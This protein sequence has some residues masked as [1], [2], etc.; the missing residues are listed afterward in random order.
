MRDVGPVGDAAVGWA[1]RRAGRE[2]LVRRGQHDDLEA[3]H[4]DQ[5]HHFE[6]VGA[7]RP[8]EPPPLHAAPSDHLRAEPDAGQHGQADQD[9]HREER[10]GIR[11]QADDRGERAAD[12]HRQAAALGAVGPPQDAHRG[13]ANANRVDGEDEREH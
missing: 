8:D 13:E 5:R 7:E 11:P 6:R 1:R 10:N 4:D 3:R 12:R 9:E 2:P